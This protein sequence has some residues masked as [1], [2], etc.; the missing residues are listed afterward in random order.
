MTKA[1]SAAVVLAVLGLA[2]FV[3]VA[4][5]LL[6]PASN[7]VSVATVPLT[8]ARRSI[9]AFYDQ[10]LPPGEALVRFLRDIPILADMDDAQLGQLVQALRYR[11]VPAGRMI[12]TQGEPGEEFFILGDGEAQVVV[13]GR[14]EPL[15]VVDVLR[16]GDSF[17]EIALI[18]RVARTASVR[19]LTDVK[20]LVLERAA[21]DRAFPE[22]GEARA[23][24]TS[25][26]RRVKLVLESPALSHLTP[27][28]VAELVR[29]AKPARFAPGDFLMRESDAGDAAYLVE[30]GDV[31]VVREASG[32]EVA[33]GGRGM[34]VGTIALLKDIKRTASVRAV[35]PVEALR[36]DKAAFLRMCV[37]NV[38]VG[39]TVADLADRQLGELQAG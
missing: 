35:T 13:G 20:T 28:Q 30:Q 2:F 11:R 3:S 32:E 37:S 4:R 6:I 39:L 5:L 34:L 9:N 21:F 31:Q 8:R 38:F 25:T 27:R 16:P 29:S 19:A 7:L 12:I 10:A 36:I 18:E 15:R 14:G 23:R 24:L 33:R 17:G 1:L 26:L 22:G